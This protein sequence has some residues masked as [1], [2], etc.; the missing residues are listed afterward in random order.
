MDFE[1]NMYKNVFKSSAAV[2][3]DISNFA[4]FKLK[5]RCCYPDTLY[6]YIKVEKNIALRGNIPVV[7]ETIIY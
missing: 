1:I 2:L 3:G 5:K 4:N 6:L 7:F